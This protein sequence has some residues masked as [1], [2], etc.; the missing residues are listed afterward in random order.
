MGATGQ[1]A[2]FLP[3]WARRGLR[4]YV[5]RPVR[6]HLRR[7]RGSGAQPSAPRTRRSPTATTRCSSAMPWRQ[8]PAMAAGRR[9]RARQRPNVHRRRRVRWMKLGFLTAPF[10]DTRARGR[11]RLGRRERLREPRDRLLA[12]VYRIGA[13]LRGHVVISTSTDLSESR[14]T[15]I[16][17]EV[18]SHGL[19]HLRTRLL[20]EPDA[21]RRRGPRRGDR[22]SEARDR[23]LREDGACRS[24]TPSWAATQRCTSMP[25][26]NGR[27]RSGRRSWRMRR[28]TA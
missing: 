25:T 18:A 21:P 3:G 12:A 4:R 8:A 5:P 16:V 7:G 19:S 22:P 11:R 9:W 27:S 10:P 13:A 2:A 1:A 17:D 28:T 6:G 14:A 20:P 23:G 24:S 15:E 26:G